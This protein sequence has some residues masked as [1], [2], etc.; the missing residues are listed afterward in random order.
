MNSFK[1]FITEAQTPLHKHCL[2]F[3]IHGLSLASSHSIVLDFSFSCMKDKENEVGGV[4][5]DFTRH[6]LISEEESH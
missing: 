2:P 3:W 5:S 1:L 4:C 6:L